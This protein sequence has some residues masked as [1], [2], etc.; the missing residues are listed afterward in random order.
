MCGQTGI[1]LGEK[2]RRAEERDHLAGC[3]PGSS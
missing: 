2:R 3:S 1:I